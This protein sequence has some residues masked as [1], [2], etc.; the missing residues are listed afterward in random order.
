[1]RKEGEDIRRERRGYRGRGGR[2]RK[3][4]IRGI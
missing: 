3:S 1:M 4:D 2:K